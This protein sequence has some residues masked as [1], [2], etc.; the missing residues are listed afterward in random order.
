M[1]S[2]RS[3]SSRK[4]ARPETGLETSIRYVKGVGDRLSLLLGKK[5]IQK[6]EDALFYFPRSYEDRRKISQ[7]SELKVGDSVCVIGRIRRF[8]P[9]SFSRSRQKRY[10]LILEDIDDPV[11]SIKL[12]WFQKPYIFQKLEAG[13]IVFA[14]GDLRAYRSVLQITHPEIELVGKDYEREMA[15]PG[16]IPIYSQTE[17]LYQKTLRKIESEVASKYS[18]LLK[19][20]LPLSIRQKYDFPNLSE[21][22]YLLHHPNA[23]TNFDE[24]LAE[25]TPAHR[26]LIYGE[27]FIF[28]LAMLLNRKALVSSP[29]ISH[30]KPD[31]LWNK[32]SESLGFRFTNA[33]RKVLREILKDMESSQVM[34]R[35]LQGDVGSGKTA[36]SAAS[37]LVA[38]GAGHQAVLMAPTEVLVRQ[39][40]EKFKTWFAEMNLDCVLLTGSQNPTE[41][42]ESLRRIKEKSPLMIFGTHALF[43]EAVEFNDLS[44]VMVDEQHRF[45]VKQ[46]AKLVGKAQ[47]PDVLV[48]TA[49]PIPRTLALTIYGD[50]DLSII[51]EMPPGR[52]PI[53]TKI[54]LDRERARM[55]QKV[56]EQL[57]MGRQAYMVFPLIEDS[58]KLVLKSIESLLPEITQSFFPYRVAVLHGKMKSEE[59]TAILDRFRQNEIQILVSTT[60]IEVGVDVPN[61]TIMIIE[62]AERFGLSQLHQ[63]R[64][65]VGRGQFESYC[66]L[67]AS[68]LG[69]PEILRRMKAMEKTQDGFELSEIDLEMRGPGE[70]IGTKQS[71]MP[72]FQ[73][74]K[75]PRDF[76][77]LQQARRDAA[78]LVEESPDLEG[79]SELSH[80][81]K[82]K[83]QAAHLT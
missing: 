26:R 76:S 15:A 47:T 18:A 6:I 5:G 61:A 56:K 57:E 78:Q 83:F 1:P 2:Y 63:L 35:M 12:V 30:P 51:D 13:A 77:I 80:L 31:L 45:G 41:K 75:L 10:E 16:I 21:A 36:V 48:M 42:K 14:T 74:A 65:R 8:F 69:S 53:A 50:L 37:A 28:S 67:C 38:L 17:G 9:V 23:E 72:N 79:F 82:T 7:V 73:M 60:V 43:E 39:H 22:V 64:G 81:I 55:N 54:Y 52:K 62:N 70:F 11:K 20:Y 59:K 33:Q 46:R 66:F 68:H 27:F 44:L 40:F 19:E 71:G 25:K 3:D 29:G 24:L 32:F 34:Y 4:P 58:E 49:T